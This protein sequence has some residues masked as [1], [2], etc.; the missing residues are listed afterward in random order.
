MEEGNCIEHSYILVPATISDINV[1]YEWQSQPHTRR[2]AINPQ[3]PTW[4]EHVSW[5]SKKIKS[6]KDCIYIV[7]SKCD[8]N[9][10]GVF[11]MDYSKPNEYVVSIYIAAEHLGAG[12]ATSVLDLVNHKFPK[13]R[14]KAIILSGNSASLHLFTKAG[15]QQVAP[16]TFIREPL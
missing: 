9:A 3:V 4:D 5:F 6:K 7:K 1:V 2:Y 10:C 11:R 16:D 13:M 8:D 14:L 12:I 15:Y